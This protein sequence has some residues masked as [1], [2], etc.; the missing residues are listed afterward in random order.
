MDTDP[1]TELIIPGAGRGY[2]DGAAVVL[3]RQVLRI[4]AFVPLRKCAAGNQ[5][6]PSFLAVTMAGME[7]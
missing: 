4:A 2:V 3:Q 1:M 6:Q 7:L 5:D